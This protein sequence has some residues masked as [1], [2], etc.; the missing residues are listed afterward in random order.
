MLHTAR[1]HSDNRRE[2]RP[3]AAFLT[4]QLEQVARERWD[5]TAV[6]RMLGTELRHRTRLRAVRLAAHVEER[7]RELD[8]RAAPGAS[9]RPTRATELQS[10]SPPAV[11]VSDAADVSVGVLAASGY[12]VGKNGAGTEARRQALRHVV[13]HEITDVDDLGYLAS[14]GR[15]GSV[16]RLRRT[17]HVL[18]KLARGARTRGPSMTSA[19]VAWSRDLAYLKER[20]Y[21]GR[22]E[23]A[24]AWPSDRS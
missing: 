12:R 7:L 18:A 13:E 14:W 2:R 15:P 4:A 6:L 24:F 22:H 5:D 3:Y 1:T 11:R 20:Y 8:S 9:S 10:A 16:E 23:N 17:A 19:R 21:D